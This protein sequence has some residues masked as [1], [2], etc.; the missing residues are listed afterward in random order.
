MP[1][2]PRDSDRFPTRA[3][4]CQHARPANLAN[5][6]CWFSVTMTLPI[7]QNQPIAP[8]ATPQA[9]LAAI[10]APLAQTSSTMEA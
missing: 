10:D 7:E 5:R 1:E 2:L 6:L 4:M 9:L 3:R 8:V